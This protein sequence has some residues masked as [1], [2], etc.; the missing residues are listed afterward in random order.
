MSSLIDAAKEKSPTLGLNQATCVHSVGTLKARN[1]IFVSPPL[2]KEVTDES[3]VVCFQNIFQ[4]FETSVKIDS[5]RQKTLALSSLS[6]EKGGPSPKKAAEIAIQ[7]VARHLYENEGTDVVFVCDKTTAPIYEKVLKDLTKG[8]LNDRIKIKI[9]DI[10]TENT[11][12][13]VC[14]VQRNYEI[15]SANPTAKAV[16]KLANETLNQPERV[17]KTLTPEAKPKEK[18]VQQERGMHRTLYHILG[19]SVTGFDP[20][21]DYNRLNLNPDDLP[22]HKQFSDAFSFIDQRYA[23]MKKL[24]KAY[25]N[26]DITFKQIEKVKKHFND[27]RKQL[28]KEDKVNILKSINDRYFLGQMDREVLDELV[29]DEAAFKDLFPTQKEQESFIKIFRLSWVQK[30]FPFLSKTL[31]ETHPESV[32]ERIPNYGALRKL[33]P[34][35]ESHV[36][37]NPGIKQFI[38]NL[39]SKG[40]PFEEYVAKLE[41][42]LKLDYNIIYLLSLSDYLMKYSP[43]T[44]RSLEEIQTTIPDYKKLVSMFS[45]LEDRK[46]ILRQLRKI[47][48]ILRATKLPIHSQFEKYVTKLQSEMEMEGKAR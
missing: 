47:E 42:G 26:K 22:T 9:G 30:N 46:E 28:T 24:E 37:I 34:R 5:E 19:L 41:Q 14:P 38:E 15:T 4:A 40:E 35:K 27:I 39:K 20:N 36:F 16:I 25:L 12:A 23:A 13:I 21:T 8:F 18:V 2:G 6:A 43:D 10:S 11:D 31:L 7:E 32:K 33:Y 44:V 3:L 45:D 48:S 17:L 1:V 29:P